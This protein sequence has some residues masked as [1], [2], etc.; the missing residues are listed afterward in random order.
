MLYR[1]QLQNSVDFVVCAEGGDGTDAVAIA[2][3][4]RPDIMLLDNSMPEMD[5]IDALPYV[6][7]ASPD[8]A[9]VIL[10]A[11]IEDGTAE[12]VL[13]LGATGCLAKTLRA[14][15]LPERLRDVLSG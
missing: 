11:V 4:F 5:G 14:G 9:V 15:P 3:E 2:R 8:T 6:L 12:R 13:A 1:A 7:E 10:S